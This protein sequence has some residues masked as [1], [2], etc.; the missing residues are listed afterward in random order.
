MTQQQVNAE[1][2]LSEDSN[3]DTRTH[4]RLLLSRIAHK[5]LANAKSILKTR[6]MESVTT[7]DI[8]RACLEE[9]QPLDIASLY[10]ENRLKQ[11]GSSICDY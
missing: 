9:C 1:V 8:L 4:I 3:F 5:N 7:D 6:G 11:K 10:L 2:D